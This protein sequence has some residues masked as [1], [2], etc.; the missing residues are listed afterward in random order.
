MNDIPLYRVCTQ[1]GWSDRHENLREASLGCSLTDPHRPSSPSPPKGVHSHSGVATP[2]EGVEDVDTGFLGMDV[3]QM[4]KGIIPKSFMPKLQPLGSKMADIRKG[5][6]RS[7]G[8]FGRGLSNSK[9]NHMFRVQGVSPEDITVVLTILK[10]HPFMGVGANR[11][12]VGLN[13]RD[14]A[15]A[16]RKRTQI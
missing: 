3:F 8:L 4:A 2:W 13:D 6:A 15:S 12:G 14:F 10:T 11:A 1:N 16:V 7:W 9:K 5:V